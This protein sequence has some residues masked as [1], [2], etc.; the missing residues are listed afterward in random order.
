MVLHKVDPNKENKQ[1]E[2]VSYN[3]KYEIN[4]Y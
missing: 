4:L 1:E 3:L 2:N